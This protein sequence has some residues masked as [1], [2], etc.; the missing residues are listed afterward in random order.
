M[1]EFK[2]P[3]CLRCNCPLTHSPDDKRQHRLCIRCHE[4]ISA[5]SNRN[6]QVCA[7]G[8]VAKC[9]PCHRREYVYA[10]RDVRREQTRK[11]WFNYYYGNWEAVLVKRSEW[12]RK[13]N[14]RKRQERQNERPDQGG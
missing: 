2:Y 7:C 8:W 3:H 5:N 1:R 6:R 11:G 13:R 4:Q 10:N 9:K 14:E 12:L